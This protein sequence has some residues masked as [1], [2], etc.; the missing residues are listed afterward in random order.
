MSQA[1]RKNRL[2]VS[3]GKADGLLGL[4]ADILSGAVADGLVTPA[5]GQ[6]L[7]AFIDEIRQC[8]AGIPR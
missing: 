5:C 6:E 7:Q 2:S 4:V 1:T 3:T 8:V